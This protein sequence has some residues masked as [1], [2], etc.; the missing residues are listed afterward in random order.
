MLKSIADFFKSVFR[1]LRLYYLPLFISFGVLLVIA[2]SVVLW[3]D[4]K[5]MPEY[6]RSGLEFSIPSV[7]GMNLD[8]A[9]TVIEADSFKVS[10]E[11]IK[12]VDATKP[13]GTILEQYPRAGAKCKHGRKIYLT[14]SKGAQPVVVP[15]LI[16]KSPQDA[17]YKIAEKKLVADSVLY[18]FSEDY[19][20]GV[21]MGQSLVVNDTVDIGDR[22]FI[23]VSVGKHP[24]EYIIPDVKGQILKQASL[25]LRK[26]GFKITEIKY[27]KNTDLLPNTI[28]DQEPVPGEI[29]YQGAEVKLVV[30]SMTE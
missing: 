20:D 26:G 3:L 15:D 22:I 21:V 28:I 23:V 1:F 2:V 4:M 13:A 18:E 16:G 30:S 8:S 5:V 6:T 11:I 19:P 25:T 7:V 14:L 9:R 17:L 27:Q 12:K 10:D 24:S 29:V